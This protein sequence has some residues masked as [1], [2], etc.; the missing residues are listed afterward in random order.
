M[1]KLRLDRAN[2][3]TYEYTS[4]RI[5]R[6]ITIEDG[7]FLFQSRIDDGRWHKLRILRK[8]RVGIIQVDKDKPERGTAQKGAS[9]L[10]TDGKVWIGTNEFGKDLKV[11]D[12]AFK[13]MLKWKRKKMSSLCNAIGFYSCF[14][15]LHFL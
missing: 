11:A 12:Q 9:V 8:R 2:R 10:N 14:T 15:C 3:I 4:N 5:W 7:Y 13:K 6:R 1:Q